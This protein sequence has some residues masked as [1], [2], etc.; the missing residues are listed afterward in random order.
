[1][2]LNLYS[3]ERRRLRGRGDLI[4][5]FKWYRDYNKEDIGKV[6]RVNNQDRTRNNVFKLEKFRFSREIGRN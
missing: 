5:V 4:E 2:V 3:L 6:L 1:M